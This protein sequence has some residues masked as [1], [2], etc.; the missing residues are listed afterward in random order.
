[1]TTPIIN[2][3]IISNEKIFRVEVMRKNQ[4]DNPITTMSALKRGEDISMSDRIN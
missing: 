3:V 4:N 1:M 2:T